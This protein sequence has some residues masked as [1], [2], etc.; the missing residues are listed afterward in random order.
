MSKVKLL[1]LFC[2]LTRV[3]DVIA[4]AD[5]TAVD[6]Y[7]CG[8][9]NYAIGNYAKAIA[10]FSA[11]LKLNSSYAE[12]YFCKATAEYILN[13]F[14]A[15]IADFS[16]ELKLNP[17]DAKAYN[18]KA[19]AEGNLGQYHKASRDYKKGSRI[20][21]TYWEVWYNKGMM[22]KKRMHYK[23]AIS[24]FS[25]ALKIHPANNDKSWYESG[26][27]KY[28]LGDIKGACSDWKNLVEPDDFDG[29]ETILKIMSSNTS[30]SK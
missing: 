14:V 21:P 29:Y 4:G 7:N 19:C 17:R 24:D 26:F 10:E 2:F 3:A 1:F 30:S 9:T 20:D 13:D 11:A 27:S 12:A 25:R 16:N 18:L 28:Y 23:K 22:E 15:A 6:H 8:K 5:S